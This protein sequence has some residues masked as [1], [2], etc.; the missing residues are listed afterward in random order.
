VI[1]YGYGGQTDF[2]IDGVTGHVI[3][4][5]DIAVFTDRC[6]SLISD[7][8]TRK[9]MSDENLVRVEEL[10]IDNCAKQYEQLFED[11]IKKHS[12]G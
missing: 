12:G 10:Y 9:R 5:N 3:P 2:L 1:C 8:E 11:V 7:H 6:R 4:L